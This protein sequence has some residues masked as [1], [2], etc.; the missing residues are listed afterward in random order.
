MANETSAS[1]TELAVPM[2]LPMSLVADR[3]R[4]ALQIDDSGEGEIL[5]DEC[6]KIKF[7]SFTL[8]H[9]SSYLELTLDSE[10]SAGLRIF[11]R[12][13]GIN[14][15]EALLVL[16]LKPAVDAQGEGVTFTTVAA[17]L[18]K[19]DGSKSLMTSTTRKLAETLLIPRLETVSVPV[20]DLLLSID[21]LLMRFMGSTVDAPSLT[22]LAHLSDVQATESGLN[23]V[24]SF[25]VELA[26]APAAEGAGENKADELTE[27]VATSASH[28]SAVAPQ[29][30]ALL[31][32]ELDGFVTTIV[33]DLAMRTDDRDLQLD[34]LAVLLDA[35]LQISNVVD[36]MQSASTLAVE[37]VETSD[38]FATGA[39]SGASAH[40]SAQTEDRLRE[41]FL[42]VWEQ[43]GELARKLPAEGGYGQERSNSA[44][45]SGLRMLGFLAAGDALL[46]VDALGP[47]YGVEISAEGLQRLAKM[48]LSGDAPV[49]F[50]PLPL[51]PDEALR[52]LFGFTDPG[53]RNNASG[54]ASAWWYPLLPVRRAVAEEVS[55]GDRL[56]EVFP[57]PSTLNDYLGI[58]ARLLEDAIEEHRT[59]SRLN[60]EQQALFEPLVRATAWKETCWRHYLPGESGVAV[61]KSS[62]GAVGMMQIVGRVWRSLFDLERLESDVNY[63]VAAGIQILDHYF[64]DYAVRRGE[65]EYPGGAENLV[66]ATYAAYNGG[67]SRLS[68]YRREG[69]AARARAVDQQFFRYY[70]EMK[71]DP[72]PQNSRCYRF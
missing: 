29:S 7:T 22:D 4:S 27:G 31:Q 11:S 57:R 6:N 25:S 36:G 14:D 18:R 55:L 59:D 60:P 43:L 9:D 17:E 34:F 5:A 30:T 16:R 19:P 52:S 37:T 42:S 67:P 70:E 47:E 51:E 68:R 20:G 71:T 2:V 69:V 56:R 58:V 23:A 44:E 45:D 28:E 26:K 3:V 50:T 63:N 46:L 38:D 66:K 10:V 1:S 12:C 49:S 62:V 35:R 32:D 72:W 39:D 33:T 48:L 8:A 64:I 54:P 40:P 15:F 13:P 53:S 65:H 24:L 61:I 21:E 41:L